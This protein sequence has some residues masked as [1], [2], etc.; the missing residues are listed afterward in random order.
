[1]YGAGRAL[2]EIIASFGPSRY[3][4]SGSSIGGS[5]GSSGGSLADLSD[6]YPPPGP[7]TGRYNSQYDAPSAFDSSYR[8]AGDSAY[9][10]I[11]VIDVLQSVSASRG[12]QPAYVNDRSSSV[13]ADFH[14]EHYPSTAWASPG[15]GATGQHPPPPPSSALH[16]SS[17]TGVTGDSSVSQVLEQFGQAVRVDP[18]SSVSAL[19]RTVAALRLSVEED[20]KRTE[21]WSHVAKET[22]R[23]LA[24]VRTQMDALFRSCQDKDAAVSSVNGELTSLSRQYRQVDSVVHDLRAD[25]TSLT[26][27]AHKHREAAQVRMVHV[28]SPPGQ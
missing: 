23:Q 8:A 14:S 16:K 21:E 6:P 24:A 11:S 27:A 15:R 1:M 18:L 10:D 17:S 5:G 22:S 12:W 19:E 13:T 25:V 2:D 7:Q 20:Q 28:L 4:A 26:A 9:P 3:E